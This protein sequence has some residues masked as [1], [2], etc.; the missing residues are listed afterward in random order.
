MVAKNTFSISIDQE[1]AQ[2]VK[3]ILK[4]PLNGDAKAIL[5]SQWQQF[6]AKSQRSVVFDLSGLEGIDPAGLIQLMILITRL[7]ARAYCLSVEGFD[8]GLVSLFRLTHLESILK[9]EGESSDNTILPNWSE[10]IRKASLKNVPTGMVNANVLGRQPTS[11]YLGFGRMRLREYYLTLPDAKVEPAEIMQVWKDNFTDF[12]PTGNRFY[13]QSGTITPGEIGLL[14][15]RMPGGFKLATGFLVGYADETSFMLMAI[16]GHMFAGWINFSCARENGETIIQIQ[17][18]IRPNDPL[19]ELSFLLGFGP[20]A[21]DD[22]WVATL[23]N[24]SKNFKLKGSIK[25]NVELIDNRIL[26]HN[27]INIK[28]NAGIGS[29]LFLLLSPIRSFATGCCVNNK[30]KR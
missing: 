12:W 29:M 13:S 3:L 28:Y 27:F 30:P 22:F 24:L 2:T 5:L 1:T 16:Q 23:E 14:N 11:P 6:N 21:E 7:R 4:G 8:Q 17:A 10:P 19:Y 25:K 9:I 20:K 15:L 26:W 18:L